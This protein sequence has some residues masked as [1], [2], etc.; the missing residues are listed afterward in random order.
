MQ[1]GFFVDDGPA[2]EPIQQVARRIGSTGPLPAAAA[3]RP[4]VSSSR[5]DEEEDDFD[6]EA[7]AAL[8]ELEGRPAAAPTASSQP[9]AVDPEASAAMRE[10]EARGAAPP[11]R[12]APRREG[13]CIE[14]GTADGQPRFLEA[15]GLSVCYDCQK[16]NKGD[17]G[18]YQMIT[19]TKA[20]DEYLLTDRQL[21]SVYG[22][23]GCHGNPRR[24]EGRRRGLD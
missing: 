11:P 6:F 3:N 21:N 19:K 2:A 16:A 13:T 14:C 7:E 8:D 18:K 15:F 1:G 9:R 12:Q 10:L 24:R 22:G 4:I 17:G 20:K 5:P 23:L